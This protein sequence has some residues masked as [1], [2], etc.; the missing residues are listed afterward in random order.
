LLAAEAATAVGLR[1]VY[2]RRTYNAIMALTMPALGAVMTTALVEIAMG[3]V[4]RPQI[5]EV[6]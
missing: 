6:L 4:T 1:T 2:R 3:G 5:Y